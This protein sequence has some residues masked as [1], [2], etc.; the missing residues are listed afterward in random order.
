MNRIA[1]FL[2]VR[3][4][5]LKKIENE[6]FPDKK[7]EPH[8]STEIF[9]TKEP[10]T[11]KIEE[12]VRKQVNKKRYQQCTPK[13]ITSSLQPGWVPDSVI[14]EGM[15]L[16]NIKPWIAHNNLGE[17][18]NFLLKQHIHPHYRNG[19]SEVHLILDDPA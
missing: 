9:C 12:N 10:D 15:F 8:V 11:K 14:M 17:Y 7:R 3:A 18:A 2:P 19:S 16:I 4:E 1:L 5:A 13:V 6:I